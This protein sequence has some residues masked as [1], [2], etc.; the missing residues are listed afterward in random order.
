MQAALPRLK[1][2]LVVAVAPPWKVIG[3]EDWHGKDLFGREIADGMMIATFFQWALRWS[4]LK[5]EPA[6]E[7][8]RLRAKISARLRTM[9]S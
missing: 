6:G 4:I 8:L 1:E 7:M 9:L 5:A 3:R 2:R